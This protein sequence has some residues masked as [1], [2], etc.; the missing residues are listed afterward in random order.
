MCTP[1]EPE[2]ASCVRRGDAVVGEA[3][4]DRHHRDA[5]AGGRVLRGVDGPATADADHR[6]V[7]PG[8]QLLAEG[9]RGVQRAAG[10]GVDVGPAQPRPAQFEHALALPRPDHHG[11][12]AARGDAP[13]SQDRAEVRD[14]PPPHLDGERRVDRAG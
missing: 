2:P 12:V 14:R 4:R 13:V 1:Y 6:V 9:E 10:D 8:A 11:H 3:G 7:R 5:V